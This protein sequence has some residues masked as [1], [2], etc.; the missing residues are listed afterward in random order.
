MQAS[1]IMT[2]PNPLQRF[3]TRPWRR[4]AACAGLALAAL[5]SA[6]VLLLAGC[7]QPPGGGQRPAPPPPP[8]AAPD[9]A[10]IDAEAAAIRSGAHQAMPQLQTLSQGPADEVA[11]IHSRNDS[12]H[13]LMLLY[14]GP[15]SQRLLLQPGTQGSVR[16][17]PGD[18]LVTARATDPQ[19]KVLPYAGR[20]QINAGTFGSSWV[21][22]SVAAKGKGLPLTPTARQVRDWFA[23]TVS[24][25]GLQESFADG[26]QGIEQFMSDLATSGRA[27]FV[28][29][30]GN[31]RSGRCA[32]LLVH[33]E[34]LFPFEATD[35]A[36]TECQGSNMVSSFGGAGSAVSRRERLGQI[37]D[38]RISGAETLSTSQP[39]NASL[40]L[41]LDGNP[42]A[43]KLA[44][45]LTLMRGRSTTVLRTPPLTLKRGDNQ[46]SQAFGA[47][48][49]RLPG[50]TAE[51]PSEGPA[52]IV[53]DLTYADSARANQLL[54]NSSAVLVQLKR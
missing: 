38:F 24:S 48:S 52:I 11:M 27:Q 30:A 41:R 23:R 34:E 29:G 20:R 19:V 15:T 26:G 16:L 33:G 14:S 17:Q 47:L 1:R 2:R 21:V 45:R 44:L 39:F 25:P 12:P 37:Q 42:P 3:V 43:D 53:A 10:S 5:A 18:Y 22:K 50:S 35:P 40:R 32:L 31:T 36:A 6:L 8:V 46:L 9:A 7:A 51:A 28:V 54:S 4:L 13:A 49:T